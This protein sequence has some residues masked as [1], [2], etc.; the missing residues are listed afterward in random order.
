MKKI[1]I[2][3]DY[4]E[5]VWP[6]WFPIF[7]ESCRYNPTVNWLF[8]ADCPDE[9]FNIE[10][11]AFNY[12]TFEDY[13]KRVRDKLNINFDPVDYYKI[14]DLRPLYADL[15]ADEIKSYDFWGWGD[16]DVIYGDIRHF[17]TDELLE[18][19]NIISTHSWCIS[20]HLA[21]IKN[22]EWLNH[23]YLNV[24]N[25][26]KFLEN[27]YIQRFEEDI[28]SKLFMYPKKLPLRW[29][30]LYDRFYNKSRKFRKNI[31]LKEQY[32]TP[33]VPSPWKNNK[34]EH[35]TVWYWK[36]GHITN[37]IDAGE[38][39]IYFHFMNFKHSRYMDPVYGTK[40]FWSDLPKVIHF[41]PENIKKGIRIDR[42]GFHELA[43]NNKL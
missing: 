9:S 42:F 3:I 1:L 29:Q 34:K 14:C 25:W 8:N 4:F 19:Y 33:L 15:Y 6:D 40:A 24:R 18:E 13:V 20:G 12:I 41:K 17:F 38:E 32:T 11:V 2:I 36:D 21:L 27:R 39:F 23:S 10:N 28:F 31:W 5:G 35:P 16:L 26:K 7:M 22:E 37:E 30:G 43:V